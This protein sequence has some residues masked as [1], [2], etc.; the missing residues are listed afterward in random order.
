MILPLSPFVLGTIARLFLRDAIDSSVLDTEDL[1]ITMAMLCLLVAVSAI[2]L[3]DK[4][5]ADAISY[6]SFPVVFLFIG[7]FLLAIFFNESY[8]RTHDLFYETRAEILRWIV[9]VFSLIVIYIAVKARYR[10]FPLED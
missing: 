2:R 5:L 10:Y 4:G 8:L 1:S 6:I 9:F 3:K 7:F